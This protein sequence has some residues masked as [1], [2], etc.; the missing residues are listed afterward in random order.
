MRNVLYP[1][2][3]KLVDCW[4]NHRGLVYRNL[5]HYTMK[6]IYIFLLLATTA[7]KAQLPPSGAA[8]IDETEAIAKA[9]ARSFQR[10]RDVQ[11]N[12]S[13]YSTVASNNFNVSFY[14]CEWQVDPAIKYI[15]GKVTSHFRITETTGSITWDLLRQLTVDSVLYHN[16]KITFEQT[17][18]HALT[19]NFPATI[20]AGALDSITIFY[21]GIPDPANTR[22]FVQTTHAGTPIIWTLSEPFG[23]KDWWPCKNGLNDKADSIDIII[24]CPQQYTASSNGIVAGETTNGTNRTT[25]FRH[26]YPIASYLV[27]FAVTNYM[28][29][30]GSVTING[31]TMPLKS[32]FYPETNLSGTEVYTQTALQQF[33]PLFGDYPFINEKYGHTQC[34]FGG[35]MEHQTNSFMGTG[36]FNHSIIAHE[37][38][39]Q[40]FGDKITCGSWSDI[41]LNEGFATYT[42]H[43]YTEINFPAAAPGGL[44]SIINNVTSLPDG[45][46]Y[47]VDTTSSSRIFS[48]RLS[49]YKGFYVVYMLRGIMGDSAFYRGVR[50]Y[51][52]DPAVRFGFARTADL[53]RNLEAESG[54]DL[55]VFFQQWIYGQGFP[56]YQLDWSQNA[57]QWIKL[58]LNQTTSHTSVPFY[59]MPVQLQL[60]SATKDTTITVEHGFSGQE[61]WVN[62]GFAVDTIMIDPKLWILS[63]VKTSQ[64]IPA[65]TTLNELKIYP[66]PAPEVL[67]IALNNPGEKKMMVWL[68]NTLGQRIYYKEI[69]LSG[70]DEQL[71]I[72]VLGLAKGIYYLHVKSGESINTT[73]KIL[74]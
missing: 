37:L 8:L 22:S 49:Y 31:K 41:W 17:V 9:E 12:N 19:V 72:P 48:S 34:G 20:N 16:N 38:G 52:N 45:S 32:Y 60:H 15:T 62:P 47:V 23:S 35:G 64:K 10:L 42:Q 33:S 57:N 29:W 59:Q 39:H 28:V 55:S 74:R 5:I 51:L 56:N 69:P 54:K 63:R 70:R 58:R 43:L 11:G 21:Q 73:R 13:V 30:Q 2:T 46:V 7:A 3:F 61:F 6:K 44:R 71:Q 26:R 25:W 18:S 4:A 40:W 67:N 1:V 50:R 36:A 14:R 65:S 68:Y 53:Q 66:N 27:A 24:T